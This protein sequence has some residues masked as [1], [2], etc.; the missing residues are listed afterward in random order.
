VIASQNDD[1]SF[2]IHVRNDDRWA[3]L[4]DDSPHNVGVSRS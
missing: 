4:A 1:E 3:Q 2:L